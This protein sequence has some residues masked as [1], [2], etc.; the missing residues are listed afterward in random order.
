MYLQPYGLESRVLNPPPL[1]PSSSVSEK[2][3]G[4]I[5]LLPSFL[6]PFLS[7][8]LATC[9]WKLGSQDQGSKA[10]RLLNYFLQRNSSSQRRTGNQIQSKVLGTLQ[11]PNI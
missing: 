4:Y 8:I 5:V 2:E 9:N 10:F 11:G 1:L 6:P 3:R 7:R